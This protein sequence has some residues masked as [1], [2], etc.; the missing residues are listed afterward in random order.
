MGEEDPQPLMTDESVVTPIA[1]AEIRTGQH[2]VGERSGDPI[3][4]ARIEFVDVGKRFGSFVAVEGLN[5]VVEPGEFLTLLGP[6]GSGKTTS[7]MLLAGFQIP[8]SGQILVNGIDVSSVPPYRRDQGVVFQ[9]YSLFPHMTV[10]QN[11]AFPLEARGAP[12]DV[13]SRKTGDALRMVRLEGLNTRYPDQLS[14][15][16]QQR[17]ALA[18]AI[19]ADPPLLLMDEPLGALDKKLREELQFE[20]KRIQRSLKVTVL[21]VTHDQ[22]EALT[23]SDRIIVMNGGQIEQV[24]TPADIYERPRT[25]FVA[26]FVGDINV[27]NGTIEGIDGMRWF[28][29][30]DGV[31]AMASP[32]WGSG[33]AGSVTAAV[34]PEKLRLD[35][36]GGS[37]D[38]HPQPNVAQA[39]G[40]IAEAIYLGQMTRYAVAVGSGLLLV[41]TMSGGQHQRV[42]VGTEVTVSWSAED[43]VVLRG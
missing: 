24:G 38:A 25:R 15:G 32:D 22:D 33:C 5:L 13:I 26:E 43:F 23:M 3:P 2:G 4:G 10:A 6:S 19:V 1:G 31:A 14:G 18:R 7:L 11:L 36:V 20:I 16:Q 28:V 12:K 35:G 30:S 39:R 8:D 40:R 41:K 42:P 29:S 9:S 34:R 37:G 27:L 17:V 21:Y